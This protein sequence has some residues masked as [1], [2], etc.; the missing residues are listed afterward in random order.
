MREDELRGSLEAINGK[1]ERWGE[2][3]R[4]L[5]ESSRAAE[6]RCQYL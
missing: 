1:V 3:Y 2:E 4:Q 5:V 6:E